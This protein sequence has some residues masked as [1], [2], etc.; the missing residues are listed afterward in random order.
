MTREELIK[1]CKYYK[2]EKECPF[3][4]GTTNALWWGGEQHLC[5]TVE[6]NSNLFDNMTIDYNDA[7]SKGWC[8]GALLDVNIPLVQRVIIYYLD[9]W[10]G[11]NYPY[12]DLDVIFT[13]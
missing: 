4:Q 1:N 7:L 5:E 2:G 12:D 6:H 3:E 8:S 9:L 10:H 11:K 13:Y